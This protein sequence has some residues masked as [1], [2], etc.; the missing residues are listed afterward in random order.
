MSGEDL[1]W[2]PVSL[3]TTMGPGCCHDLG[4]TWLR[5]EDDRRGV[6]VSTSRLGDAAAVPAG[7]AG[8]GDERAG[9]GGG[10]PLVP[11]R[12]W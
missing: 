7:W 5:G 3:A 6:L 12:L 1:S 10:V 2:V 4:T 8:R 9:P 11:G